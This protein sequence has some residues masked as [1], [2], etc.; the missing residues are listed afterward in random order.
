MTP[1]LLC[2][3]LEVA[4]NRW[5]CLE[6]SVIE[7]LPRLAGKSLE[8]RNAELCWSLFICIDPKRVAVL[9]DLGE[10][11]RA[12]VRV[13]AP[14]RAL[15]SLLGRVAS[16][17]PGFPPS[18]TVEGDAELLARFRALLRQVGFDAEEVLEPF[19]GGSLAHRVV[20]G[21][22][23]LGRWLRGSADTLA[24]DTAEYLREETR[25]LARKVDVEEWMDEVDRLREQADRV[26]ARLKRLEA[27][28][29]DAQ[30]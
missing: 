8:F 20:G 19:I 16:D 28:T 25:D 26:E 12:D 6:P 4:L 1:M 23:G 3:A 24:Q 5:L 22:S 30:A 27:R 17:D 13:T 9:P 15:P 18:V 21:L 10:G 14:L 7:R 2:A 29:R 11:A